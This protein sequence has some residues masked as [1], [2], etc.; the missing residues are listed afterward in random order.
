MQL[1]DYQK[2]S[3]DMLYEWLRNNTGH[4]CVVL[5]TGAGK[6]VIIAEL[7][8]NA[9]QEWPETTVLMLCHQKELIEQNAE[10]MRAM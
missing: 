8:K 10:K 3:I 5:P 1:R 9:L 2:R 4:V 6:S 7:A